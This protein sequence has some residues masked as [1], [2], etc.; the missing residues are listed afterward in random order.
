M[1]GRRVDRLAFT[2]HGVPLRRIGSQPL[3]RGIFTLEELTPLPLAFRLGT[4]TAGHDA[5]ETLA[6]WPEARDAA[7][8]KTGFATDVICVHLNR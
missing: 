3:V 4:K 7:T 2:K 8:R 6:K 5:V 1:D